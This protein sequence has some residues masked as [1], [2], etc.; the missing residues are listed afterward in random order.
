MKKYLGL[1]LALVMLFSVGAPL[2]R[3]ENEENDNREQS[4]TEM[5]EKREALREEVKLRLETTRE[6]AKQ[7]MEALRERIKEGRDEA[8]AKV[9]ELRIVGREKALERFDKAI[10]R[11]GGLEEKISAKLMELEEKGIDTT[12]AETL[13]ETAKD[14]L[15]DAKSKVV[16]MNSLLSTSLDQLTLENKTQLRTWA[17]ETRTLLVEAHRALVDAIKSMKDAVKAQIDAD[18]NE[19]ESEN[20]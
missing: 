17:Q 14:K 4:R 8:K 16:E 6:E 13:L 1:L 12:G 5:R 2:V 3:A 9:Q 20:D 10:E 19:E 15:A 7:K 11:M 18:D